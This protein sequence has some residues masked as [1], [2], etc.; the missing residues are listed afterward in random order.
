MVWERIVPETKVETE[1]NGR[2][3]NVQ[4]PRVVQVETEAKAG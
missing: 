3:I 2:V 4:K 1:A